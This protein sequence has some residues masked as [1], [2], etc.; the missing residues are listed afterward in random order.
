MGRSNGNTT[1]YIIIGILVLLAAFYMWNGSSK[2]SESY[3]NTKHMSDSKPDIEFIPESDMGDD[4]QMVGPADVEEAHAL[5][6]EAFI[7]GFGK[8]EGIYGGT[9]GGRHTSPML[10]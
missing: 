9:P 4:F 2:K 1:L 6:D 8:G 10:G 7:L 5:Q 3:A